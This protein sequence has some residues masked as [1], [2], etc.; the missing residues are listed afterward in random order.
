MIDGFAIQ[1]YRSYGDHIQTMVYLDKM[2]VIIGKN[3]AGKSNI[4]R[5]LTFLLSPL[6]KNTIGATLSW[7]D[8]ADGADF[9]QAPPKIGLFVNAQKIAIQAASLNNSQFKEPLRKYADACAQLEPAGL[10][11]FRKKTSNGWE[12]ESDP[13]AMIAARRAFDGTHGITIKNAAQILT[14]A[15][16]NNDELNASTIS[17]L[18]DPFK[19]DQLSALIPA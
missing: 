10:W 6:A 14:N 7:D 15:S 18:F 8:H 4:L 9:S 13:N 1:N 16:H 17:A 11:Y 5:A 12:F 19:T 2:N 3:N